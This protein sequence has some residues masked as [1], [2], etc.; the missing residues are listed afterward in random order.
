MPYGT[1]L[2]TNS[3]RSVEV[4]FAYRIRERKGPV[5]VTQI[6][7]ARQNVTGSLFRP[8]NVED[9]RHSRV[10]VASRSPG[11]RRRSVPMAI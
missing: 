7:A 9:S 11:M 6:F 5:V 3:S 8:R 4:H 1:W 10:E 2:W